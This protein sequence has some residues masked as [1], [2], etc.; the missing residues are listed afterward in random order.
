M[1]SDQNPMKW[2]DIKRP[3]SPV[4]SEGYFSGS[5]TR[6]AIVVN[7]AGVRDAWRMIETK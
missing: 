4:A 5:R 1:E 3:V 7:V 6:R 2:L